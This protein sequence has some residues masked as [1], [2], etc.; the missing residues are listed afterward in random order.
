MLTV[1]S[2]WPIDITVFPTY[3]Q[4]PRSI[5]SKFH[6]NPPRQLWEP[7]YSTVLW[8]IVSF[9]WPAKHSSLITSIHGSTRPCR[10]CRPNCCS[11]SI[12]YK[13]TLLNQPGDLAHDPI[14]WLEHHGAIRWFPALSQISGKLVHPSEYSSGNSPRTLR[15]NTWCSTQ[16]DWNMCS[17]P[18]WVG[19]KMIP[20]MIGWFPYGSNLFVGVRVIIY[21]RQLLL[22]IGIAWLCEILVQNPAYRMLTSITQHVILGL[23]LATLIPGQ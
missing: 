17:I 1:T 21:Y 23:L 13:T 4:G 18:W 7:C 8:G 22:P 5:V 9:R 2:W 16:L 3:P 20:P 11:D 10:S 6:W 15:P 14:L 19:T 12:T